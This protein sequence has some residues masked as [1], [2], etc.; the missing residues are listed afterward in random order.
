M[1]RILKVACVA[2]GCIG[3]TGVV[4]GAQEVIHAMTGT[5]R[6]IDSTQKTFTL[7]RDS[8][9]LITFKDKTG[10]KTQIANDEKI[11]S[12]AA[13]AGASD[14][15][16]AYVIVFYYGM[17]DNPTAVAVRALGKGPFTATVGTVTNF[18]EK[19][20]SLTVKDESGSIHNYKISA[21][22][23]AESDFGV[24]EGYKIH[25]EKGGHIR[26]VGEVTNDSPTALFLSLM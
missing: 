20:R 26:V 18:S 3:F 11:F 13:A 5:V 16:D 23:V 2:V 4:A 19:A 12:D 6:S 22:T 14:K 7:F 8:G 24:V 9:S 25:A 21:D 15:K 1:L 17:T 10:S